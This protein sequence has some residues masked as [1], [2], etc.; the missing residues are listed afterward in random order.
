MGFKKL[1]KKGTKGLKKLSKDMNL[2][3][4]ANKYLNKTLGTHYGE[5]DP[6]KY[7]KTDAMAVGFNRYIRDLGGFSPTKSIQRN[8]IPGYAKFVLDKTNESNEARVR[9]K[10]TPD[11]TLESDELL[12]SPRI[13]I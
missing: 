6:T 10:L 4:V 8:T 13:E 2:K 3:D 1:V 12:A 9:S 11:L 7:D 5:K